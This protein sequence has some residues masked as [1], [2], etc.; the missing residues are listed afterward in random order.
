LQAETSAIFAASRRH[1]FAPGD[2]AAALDTPALMR[3]AQALRR[4]ERRA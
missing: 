4:A 1:F 3:L 2:D